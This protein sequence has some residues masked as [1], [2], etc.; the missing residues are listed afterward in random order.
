[1][2]RRQ[3]LAAVGVT[4]AGGLAG[5]MEGTLGSSSG[6]SPVTEQE[7]TQIT[8]R[9]DRRKKHVRV[10][11]DEAANAVNVVGVMAYGSPEC[12]RP[13]IA[14][15]EY[16]Q[17]NDQLSVRLEPVERADRP[18][19]CSSLLDVSAYRATFRFANSLPESVRVESENT[20]SGGRQPRA[21]ET[22][23]R[24]VERTTQESLCAGE[25]PDDPERAAKA[26]WTCPESY[27]RLSGQ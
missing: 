22:A 25:R 20:A 6:E 7:I 11:W 21:G 1:M 19:D 2:K 5:C 4:T 23:E 3:M 15:T 16:D 17:Q 26:H 8:P 10:R 13:S 18:E 24:T 14:N 12:D 27:L 9:R